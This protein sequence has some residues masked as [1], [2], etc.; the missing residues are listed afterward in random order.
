MTY[1]QLPDPAVTDKERATVRSEAAQLFA[2]LD[3]MER[4]QLASVLRVSVF[5][6]AP[7]G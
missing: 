7:P 2:R 4:R 5:S 3:P 1:Q 6:V